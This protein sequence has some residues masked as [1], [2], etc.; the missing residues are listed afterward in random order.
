LRRLPVRLAG[1]RR[2]EQVTGGDVTNF[3]LMVD[4][5]LDVLLVMPSGALSPDSCRQLDDCLKRASRGH[6]GVVVDLSASVNLPRCA[7]EVLV[8]A[9]KRLG[10]RLSIVAPRGEPAHAA[11]R[12]A[13]IRHT[14][15]VH[16]SRPAALTAARPN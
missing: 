11:L 2:R 10:A 13:G 3:R 15:S 14:F 7:I 6:R 16:N 5:I 9:R 8:A 12:A 1:D 4:S